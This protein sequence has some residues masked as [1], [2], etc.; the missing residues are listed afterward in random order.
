M[1]SGLP[2]AA[3]S[4]TP[5]GATECGGGLS[6]SA[7]ADAGS[8]PET[9]QPRI[10]A[11]GVFSVTVTNV[12]SE[13]SHRSHYSPRPGYKFVV[14]YLSQQNVSQEARCTPDVQPGGQRGRLEPAEGLSNFFLAVLRPYGINFGY[15][16][17]EIPEESQPTRL[18]LAV[19]NGPGLAVG[20]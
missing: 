19:P 10:A 6:Q 16:T 12:E 17:F 1:V 7:S 2:P 3:T 11:N 18:V 15:L 8:V 9:Y 4:A 5:V 13:A 20:L 14:V